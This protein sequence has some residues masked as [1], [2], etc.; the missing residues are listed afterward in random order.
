VNERS[1]GFCILIK[2]TLGLV[3]KNAESTLEETLDSIIHQD[4]PNQLM[5]IIVVDGMS[6]DKTMSM[7]TE[8]FEKENIGLEAFTTNEGLGQS[9]QI[10]VDNAKG[11]YIIWVDGDMVIPE[12]FVKKQ[13]A[14][15][16]ENPKAG[17]GACY[18]AYQ[19][20]SSWVSSCQNIL[21]VVSQE[22]F[23]SIYRKSALDDVKGFDS[24]I[25]GACE[26]VDVITR[27][28]AAGWLLIKNK[29][30]RLLHNSKTTLKDSLRRAEWNGYGRHFLYHKHSARV[31]YTYQFVLATPI[32]AF[33]YGLK[34][35]ADAYK[36]EKRKEFILIPILL[37]LEKI[38]WW[39]G[40]TKSHLDGYGHN[41]IGGSKFSR[42]QVYDA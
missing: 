9:R 35:T 13:V 32:G 21:Y 19:K 12:G 20:G 15:M 22:F 8:G 11:E 39:L 16:E 26:D 29:N 24:E 40:Y 27:I 4:F 10:V 5:E 6:R 14:L 17:I 37:F 31:G 2:V 30:V 34:K 28:T 41:Q 1:S 18:Y 7:V 38:F 25:K 42:V 33:I 36:L 3:V 23:C